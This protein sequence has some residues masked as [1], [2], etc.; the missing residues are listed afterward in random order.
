MRLLMS[1]VAVSLGLATSA[2]AQTETPSQQPAVRPPATAAPADDKKKDGVVCKRETPTGSLF[3]VK[4][5][6]TAEQR[7]A[8]SASTRKAQDAMQGA[9][10][11]IPN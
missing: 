5:C 2:L 1:V 3:P 8:E 10:P 6:T 4:V 11:T 7:K 9:G